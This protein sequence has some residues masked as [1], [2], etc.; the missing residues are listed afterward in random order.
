MVAAAGLGRGERVLAAARTELH[1]WL[2]VT[3]WRLL[4]IDGPAASGEATVD[5]RGAPVVRVD[6]PWLDVDQGGWQPEPGQLS[7]VWVGGRSSSWT[8]P[9]DPGRLPEAFR[10]RVSASVVLARE[11]D[12]G[13]RRRSRVV[14]RQRLDT[15]ELVEQVL[16]G[17]GVRADDEELAA[18]VARA[19]A[20]LRDQV[21]MPPPT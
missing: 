5:P 17:K 10:D 19:R 8:V 20:D 3:T 2:V 21:G 11:V 16:P 6:R 1:T 14:I 4:E 15:R 13:P 12:L 7:A 18:S 9:G